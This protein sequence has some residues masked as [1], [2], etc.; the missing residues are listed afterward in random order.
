MLVTDVPCDAAAVRPAVNG[1]ISVGIVIVA[2]FVVTNVEVFC[3]RD[4]DPAAVEPAVTSSSS[5]LH[6]I[7]TSKDWFTLMVDNTGTF[8]TGLNGFQFLC[9]LIARF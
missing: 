9:F 8:Y 1:L 4:M 6:A 7:L 5:L 2:G 3:G